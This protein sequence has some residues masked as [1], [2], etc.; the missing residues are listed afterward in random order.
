MKVLE[1]ATLAVFW[2]NTNAPIVLF[3]PFPS[4]PHIFLT[5]PTAAFSDKSTPKVKWASAV[6]YV[7]GHPCP[8]MTLSSCGKRAT[9]SVAQVKLLKC[10]CFVRLFFLIL[11]LPLVTKQFFHTARKQRNKKRLF[12][13]QERHSNQFFREGWKCRRVL[14][15]EGNNIKFKSAKRP[16]VFKKGI[17]VAPTKCPSNHKPANCMCRVLQ[18]ACKTD[19]CACI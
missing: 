5:I 14:S 13:G 1:A 16:D 4:L 3:P 10:W 12:V 2:D 18:S 7:S 19:S 17:E 6:C 15:T 8:I 9:L 11:H